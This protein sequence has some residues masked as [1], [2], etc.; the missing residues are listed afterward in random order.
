MRT[1][2]RFNFTPAG[3]IYCGRPTLW[4]N[5]FEGRPRIGHARSVILYD[6]WIRGQ[7]D[8]HVLLCCGFG[9]HEIAALWRWRSRLLGRIGVLKGC[10]LQCWCPL[11]SA[12]CHVEIL[13]PA[14]NDNDFLRVAA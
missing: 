9:E 3:A 10:D 11:T 5:P 12:W 7:L 4:A 2:K 14:A 6:A 1:R 8:A 13:L